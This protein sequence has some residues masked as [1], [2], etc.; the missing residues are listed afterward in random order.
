MSIVRESHT[1]TPVNRSVLVHFVVKFEPQITSNPQLL[2]QETE[3]LIAEAQERVQTIAAQYRGIDKSAIT[4]MIA[5]ETLL[6]DEVHFRL[7]ALYDDTSRE[8]CKH[9]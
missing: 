9:P 2:S 8:R 5:P 3:Q 6:A 7:A 1:R 4:V